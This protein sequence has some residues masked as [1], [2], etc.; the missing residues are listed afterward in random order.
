MRRFNVLPA[1]GLM[2]VLAC[3]AEEA[4]TTNT[5][6]VEPLPSDTA[7]ADVVPPNDTSTTAPYDAQFLDTM[8]AHH[9]MGVDMARMQIAK[10]AN[11]KLK[12]MSQKTAD[13][14]SAE[15]AQMKGWR[16]QWYASEPPAENRSLPG[17]ASMNMDMAPMQNL[18]GAQHD[19]MYLDMMISHHEGAIAMARDAMQKAEHAELKQLAQQIIADQEKEIAELRKMKN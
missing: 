13:K 17:G 7:A 3:S 5:D 6:A 15:I 14:Q 19:S 8:A 4:A 2:L 9:Q 1:F 12:E 11:A 10:G 16:D 18:T